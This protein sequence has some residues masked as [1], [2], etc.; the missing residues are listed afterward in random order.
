MNKRN[1]RFGGDIHSVPASRQ[2]IDPRTP[3]G[4]R[5]VASPVTPVAG[6]SGKMKNGGE[7]KSMKK[8]KKM[9]M[10]G[11]SGP[12]PV[13]R[14]RGV[15]R[16]SMAPGGPGGV[17]TLPVGPPKGAGGAP[18]MSFGPQAFSPDGARFA[19]SV[20]PLRG[21]FLGGPGGM[22]QGLPNAMMGMDQMGAPP[23]GLPNAMMGMGQMGDPAMG[24]R[25]QQSADRAALA[26][27]SG[28][29]RPGAPGMKK[30]GKVNASTYNDMTGGAAG[31]IGRL[32][33]S[34][35]AAKT[36]TQK[37]KKGGTVKG[38]A[39]G[40][41]VVADDNKAFGKAF[42]DARRDKADEFEW[43]GKKYTTK[44]ADGPTPKQAARKAMET[45]RNAGGG[46]RGKARSPVDDGDM[47]GPMSPYPSG[48]R[49]ASSGGKRTPKTNPIEGGASFPIEQRGSSPSSRPLVPGG[50]LP[51]PPTDFKTGR[52]K[53]P[54]FLERMFKVPTPEERDAA[55]DKVNESGMFGGRMYYNTGRMGEG[56]TGFG[57]KKGGKVTKMAKGGKAE[58]FEG[59]A[60]DMAQDKKLAKKYGMTKK[61]YEKSEVDAKH[62]KQK[63]MKGLKTGGTTKMASGGKVK[64]MAEGGGSLSSNMRGRI[65]DPF[66]ESAFDAAMT[67][68][69]RRMG[70]AYYNRDKYEEAERKR[71]AKTGGR[72]VFPG[73]RRPGAMQRAADAELKYQGMLARGE[74][75][76]LDMDYQNKNRKTPA[77]ERLPGKTP[78]PV[79]RPKPNRS[80]LDKIEDVGKDVGRY[81]DRFS[82]TPQNLFKEGGEVK[83]MAKGGKTEM[84]A[85]GCK[86]MACGGKVKYAMGGGVS[87]AQ[88]GMKPALRPK[89]TAMAKGGKVG[90]TF[91]KPLPGTKVSSQK[92]RSTVATGASMKKDGMKGQLR[93]KASGAKTSSMMKPL[94]MTKMASGGK[95]R[96][97]GIAQRG[98]KF[99]GEV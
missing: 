74:I 53:D 21:G 81:F 9:A 45:P 31:G 71:T 27:Q 10:G 43:R 88:D 67:D 11:M 59:S 20:G 58:A 84:H 4:V 26:R 41:Q 91:G 40:K 66:R 75:S 39:D 56:V 8:T 47:V 51:I 32:E 54:T 35:I 37:L 98:T 18:R 17:T 85:K 72:S 3:S 36:K 24:A 7:V 55:Y 60:K 96:G 80:S 64:R 52:R 44:L 70:T 94:G 25:M 48:G 79:P 49:R 90:M 15:S 97:A 62:D 28:G 82:F 19:Q 95:V 76:P 57:K 6:V 1:Y 23:R 68:S 14:G 92:I 2:N 30:G 12:M 73:D 63:S 38:Y 83:K 46:P 22:S 42:A 29:M 78:P 99:I 93:A 65:P 34:S 13:D 16:G 77:S 5:P 69:E 33:K 61:A 50:P 87:T 86:C 89:P